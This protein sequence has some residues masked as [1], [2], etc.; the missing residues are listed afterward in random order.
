MSLFNTVEE[1]DPTTDTWSSKTPMPTNRTE[2]AIGIANG[3]I[4][5]IDGYN[6]SRLK[7]VGEGTLSP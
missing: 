2:L 6:G 7:T 5:A 1:Y 4:Y 3:K